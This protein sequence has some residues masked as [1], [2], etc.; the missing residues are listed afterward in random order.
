M[1]RSS[2]ACHRRALVGGALAL[3]AAAVQSARSGQ[4]RLQR[5]QMSEATARADRV[6]RQRQR[7]MRK[8]HAVGLRRQIRVL[9]RPKLVEGAAVEHAHAGGTARAERDDGLAAVRLSVRLR[10]SVAS[11][12]A[13]GVALPRYAHRSAQRIAGAAGGVAGGR[14]RKGLRRA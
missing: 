11:A 1:R 12:A 4:F 3:L 14:S 5:R 7:Q 9:V 8:P 2:P 10:K 13:S 6:E